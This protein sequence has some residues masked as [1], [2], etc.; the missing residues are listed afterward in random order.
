VRSRSAF[1]SAEATSARPVSATDDA[2]ASTRR[3]SSGV[4]ASIAAIC[5]S[6]I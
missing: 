6:R 4:I 3:C 5:S 1:T 2:P